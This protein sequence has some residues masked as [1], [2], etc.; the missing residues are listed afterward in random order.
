MAYLQKLLLG[1]LVVGIMCV[2]NF[3][4]LD[5]SIAD[6]FLY[7]CIG[8]VLLFGGSFFVKK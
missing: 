1:F 6:R 2:I 8:L 4:A 7:G 3:W 5:P